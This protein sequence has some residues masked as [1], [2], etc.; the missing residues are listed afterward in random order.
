MSDEIN[1]DLKILPEICR[2]DED[3]E[4]LLDDIFELGK[5]LLKHS[6]PKYTKYFQPDIITHI[7]AGKTLIYQQLSIL[8]KGATKKDI[9]KALTDNTMNSSET[10]KIPILIYLSGLWRLKI[11]GHD[12]ETE[13][14]WLGL[15]TRDLKISE[16]PNYFI[17][18]PR[19]DLHTSL[20]I[21]TD[22]ACYIE[23]I[24]FGFGIEKITFKCNN[25]LPP[26]HFSKIKF[27]SIELS[28]SD[29]STQ[30]ISWWDTE[31]PSFNIQDLTLIKDDNDN[32]TSQGAT[33]ENFKMQICGN[34]EKS[35]KLENHTCVLHLTGH[36]PSIQISNCAFP[37]INWN[38]CKFNSLPNIDEKSSVHHSVNIDRKTFDSLLNC[39]SSGSLEFSRLAEFFN[40]NNAY[41]EAQQLH[42]HY[43]KTKAKESKNWG[44]KAWIWLYDIINECGT[45]LLIPFLYLLMLLYINVGILTMRFHQVQDGSQILHYA[46][47]NTMPF[48]GMISSHSLMS[49]APLILLALNITA[50]LA[51]LLWFLIALQIRKTL[52]LRE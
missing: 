12:A 39:E 16:D 15:K 11:T 25:Q 18:L 13:W 47:K 36:V 19:T 21:Q 14:D 43:L 44:L 32:I 27:R 26:V 10:Y 9:A 38:N 48:L 31:V 5:F 24:I 23:P 17:V 6:E 8:D 3:I 51:T 1:F 2:T 20:T 52:R 49:D 33:S 4:L 7:R 42:R 30:S 45:N 28:A 29:D 50:W 34:D 46:I 35:V 37:K 40:R 41:L 22:I